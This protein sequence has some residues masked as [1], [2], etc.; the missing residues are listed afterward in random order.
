MW[1]EDLLETDGNE[2]NDTTEDTYNEAES[3]LFSPCLADGLVLET[4][5]GAEKKVGCPDGDD[6]GENA[7]GSGTIVVV[8]GGWRLMTW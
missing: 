7:P 3:D 8:L 1:T 6:T 4:T 5:E 2:T